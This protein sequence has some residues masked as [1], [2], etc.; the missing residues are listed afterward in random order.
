M[1]LIVAPIAELRPQ[2]TRL[3]EEVVATSLQRPASGR[4][5]AGAFSC[6]LS[7]GSTSLIFLGALRDAAVDWSRITIYWADERAVPPDHP[8]SNYGLAERL[9]LSPLGGRAPQAVRMPA[10]LPDLNQAAVQYDRALPASLDLLILGM[11][12]DGHVCSLFPNHP[13]LNVRDVRVTAIEDSPKPPPR[14]LTL[15]MP[16]VVGSRRVW[17]VALGAR[18]LPVLQQAVMRQTVSTPLDMVTAQ[19]KSVTIFTD[20]TLRSR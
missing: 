15:T 17:V 6:G 14:R 16:Y 4:N 10:D 11:G 20:E 7:G 13:A 12:D 3:F 19:A 9:L 1:E 5:D 2:I 18:K 8:D